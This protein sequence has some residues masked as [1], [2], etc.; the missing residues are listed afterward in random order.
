MNISK[1]EEIAL[2]KS[3]FDKLYYPPTEKMGLIVVNNFPELG[4]LTAMRFLEW[5]QEN[6]EGVISLP[7]G[8]TPEYFIKWVNHYLATWNTKETQLDLGKNGVDMSR[9][10]DLRGLYFVQIDEFYPIYPTW[11]NSF[12]FYV[13]KF[14]IDGFGL[15]PAR[16]QLI[17]A[18]Q[19]GIPK[20]VKLEDIWPGYEVDLSLRYRH[21]TNKLE[22]LQKKVLEA[23][24]QWCE[25]YEEKIREKGGIGFFLGGIGP[26]GHIAFNVRGSDHHSTTRLTYTNYETQA[27]AAVDLGGIEI[28]RKRPVI[29][30]GLATITYNPNAV[31][32]IFA[33]GEAKAKVVRDA[34][35]NEP[36]IRYPATA[37]HKL[38]NSRF[39]I[40]LG[41]AKLLKERQHLLLKQKEFIS[42][43]D[44]EKI[45]I[46]LALRLKKRV[47]NLTEQDFE[48]DREAQLILRKTGKSPE[49][50]LMET[51]KSLKQK[52]ADGME[53]FNNTTFLHTS[54]H[55][56]DIMLGYL[57]FVVRN[58]RNATNRH[59]FA[60][61]T[62]GFTAVTNSF[63]ANVL[64]KVKRFIFTPDFIEMWKNGYFDPTNSEGRNRDVWQYLDGIAAQSPYMKDEGTARR[65]IRN[66]V[67]NY[68]LKTLEEIDRKV[69][70]IIDYLESVYP[71]KK[72]PPDIQR[73][74]GMIREWEADCLWGYLGIR[75][76]SVK[77]LRLGFYT[78]DIFTEEPTV[79]RDVMPVLQ[80]LRQVEP[81]VVT[82]ALD[83]EASGPDTHYKVLQT[84][85]EALKRY[86][87]ES[88]KHDIAVFG[89]RNVWYRFHPSESNFYVPVSLNMFAI[90][91]NAFKN[92]F[93]SQKDASFPSYEHDGPFSELSQKIQTEQYHAV[94]TLLGR[95]FFHNHMS[96]LIRA[97]R[98]LVFLKQMSLKE[99]YAHARELR[100]T[101]EN[102]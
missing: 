15:D 47:G 17:D 45:V 61:M 76:D 84:V 77:H 57:P 92:A 75:C 99:F 60:Y 48:K 46:D 73:F 85:A 49:D 11:E 83:P 69:D 82:V 65:M 64:K 86:E 100:K 55:H 62:S 43:N 52:I 67:E 96:P 93:V 13:K 102:I 98:G 4:K 95:G 50:L 35:E 97:T 37:L 79:E 26:D 88:G 56:D 89:Y 54:P 9:K 18:T 71:G 1:V 20:G 3:K 31:A 40:T 36:H 59:I 80:L 44:V 29:T 25:G 72:D 39:Y 78:G 58:I 22:R 68:N 33:A 53:V 63:T 10:P 94:K 14:Y 74:K 38:E 41:A 7:T 21:P 5:V 6:P 24:D 34:I 28:A 12:Y 42:K 81:D 90:M 101:T 16:A 66:L 70:E 30:I 2:Q 87:S 8:K 19:I 91:E 27:A 32:I 23:V 51:S